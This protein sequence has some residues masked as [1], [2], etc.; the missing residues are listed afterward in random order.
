MSTR[1]F[2]KSSFI[3]PST[4][5]PRQIAKD[6]Q[7]T[8]K[9]TKNSGAFFPTTKKRGHIK[10]GTI[11][12]APICIIIIW[13]AYRKALVDWLTLRVWFALW[14][15]RR[16]HEAR[17]RAGK[18]YSYDVDEIKKALGTKRLTKKQINTSLTTLQTLGIIQFSPTLISFTTDVD[19]LLSTPL[20]LQTTEMRHMLD[21]KNDE[22]SI[23]FPRR[24]L[25]FIICAKTYNPVLVGTALA[26][27]MRCMLVKRYGQYK[28][29]CRAGWIASIFGGD[30]TSIASARSK[31]VS[32]GWF[33]RL[34]T[35]QRVKNSHGQWYAL[36]LEVV[37]VIEEPQEAV[38]PKP[39]DN[40]EKMSTPSEGPK[41]KKST[42]SEG[43]NKN[44]FLSYERSKNQ[45]TG[46]LKEQKTQTPTPSSWS[47]FQVQD[48]KAP[49]KREKL[50]REVVSR[51]ILTNCHADKLTFFAASARALRVAKRNPC[52]LLRKLIEDRSARRYISQD[53]ENQ[54]LLW[55]KERKQARIPLVNALL[56]KG[57]TPETEPKKL[58]QDALIVA[59]LSGSLSRHGVSG[60][61]YKIVTSNA[62]GRSKLKDW[63]R[64]RWETAQV[65][66]AQHRL[67]QAKQRKK[68][69][70]I[71][72]F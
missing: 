46:F 56:S 45:K 49:Q 6:S 55:L 71:G 22:R 60:D 66:L 40:S 23:N 58:S 39:V 54:A 14:E 26:L 5:A 28:G 64:K 17:V 69:A 41:P 42:P 34:E 62:H 18:P 27:V 51:G 13:A 24:I 12:I 8:M 20:R 16:W 57:K 7:R 33:T 38:S 47:D 67:A 3:S 30:P 9:E 68:V 15:V 59:E 65:E 63:T 35:N 44:Q 48:I 11:A 61:F 2:G 4:D 1:R 36:A 19:N 21:N 31:L 72:E 52:G 43:L 70:G 32:L 53:D 25:N 50:F 29:C 10:G 37:V